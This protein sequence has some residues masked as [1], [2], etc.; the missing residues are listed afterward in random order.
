MVRRW[1][2]PPPMGMGGQYISKRMGRHLE[3]MDMYIALVILSLPL[4]VF[5]TF[6]YNHVQDLAVLWHIR[7]SETIFHL[8]G[9]YPKNKHDCL[10]VHRNCGLVHPIQ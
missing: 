4:D 8:Q 3:M 9:S 7:H 1:S 10:M 6:G 5:K 2:A